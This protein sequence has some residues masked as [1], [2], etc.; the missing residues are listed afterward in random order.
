MLNPTISFRKIIL[1][2]FINVIVL[3]IFL[4][5]KTYSPIVVGIHLILA[6]V[7]LSSLI[8]W[9]TVGPFVIERKNGLLTVFILV[10]LSFL[11]RI[12]LIEQVTPGMY[13][14]EVTV[15]Q[16]AQYLQTIEAI[17]P[18]IGGY[19]HPTPLLYMTGA[20]MDILGN[21]PMAIRL[22]SIIFGS[23]TVSVFYLLLRLF[24]PSSFAIIGALLFMT[25]YVHIVISRLA[26]EPVASLFFQVLFVY[27]L[28]RYLRERKISLLAL[29]GATLGA[30]LYTYLNFRLF[31]LVAILTV[32]GSLFIE[33]SKTMQKSIVVFL[34]S[35][36]ILV[37][38]L[39]SFAMNDPQGFWGRANELSIFSQGFTMEQFINELWANTYRSVILPF[40]GTLGSIPPFI[41]DPNPGKNPAGVPFFDPLTSILA[42]IGS[43]YL[44][45][46][47]RYI[48]SIPLLFLIPAFL[49][50]ILSVEV[51]P[52]FHYFGLGHPNTL[53]LSGILGAT[54]FLAVF[55]L[56]QIHNFLK[57][58]WGRNERVFIV[59]VVLIISLVNV[60]WY[61]R[62]EVL[63]R[64][65][66]LYN[67]K[68]NKA[69]ILQMIDYVNQR[70]PE[71]LAVTT[72]LAKNK[73]YYDVFLDDSTR[74]TEFKLNTLLDAQTAIKEHDVVAIEINRSTLGI[75]NQLLASTE[76]QRGEYTINEVKGIVEQPDIILFEKK[77]L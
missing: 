7:F 55:G 48:L 14:D 8:R 33:K 32:V 67:Y 24:L 58:K 77:K 22:P 73:N 17:P 10:G 1:F 12:F 3:S 53:R 71:Q 68:V 50:D 4:M 61:F 63:N 46:K 41:G 39:L 42:C 70:S 65:F 45:R 5:T 75:V 43:I 51:I 56:W 49:S 26:Y 13:S 15:A 6:T 34:S 37:V 20:A 74:I 27:L 9:K 60:T 66:F 30:G 52:D 31:A 2:A 36:F 69:D 54:L 23:L 19:S 47:N 76:Y 38:P 18:F 25:Q 57:M 21:S 29:L 16:Y 64:T 62:Q 59:S 40:G 28:I 11:L 72:S 44:L 35:L